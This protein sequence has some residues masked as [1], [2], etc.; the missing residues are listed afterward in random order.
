MQPVVD[1]LRED[2]NDRVTFVALDAE[3]EGRAAFA[4]GSLPGHPSYVIM[5]ADG[6]E[7]WRGFGVLDEADII[8]ALDAALA[9]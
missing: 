7:T 6:T 9:P 4:A 2:Y 1:R 3:G 5:L 8:A